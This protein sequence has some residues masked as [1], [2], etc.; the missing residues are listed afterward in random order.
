[1]ESFIERYVLLYKTTESAD[2]IIVQFLVE[3][4][5]GEAL[6]ASDPDVLEIRMGTLREMELQILIKLVEVYKLDKNKVA[7]LLKI[8]RTTLWKKLKTG[9]YASKWTVN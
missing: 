4:I 2:D 1:L 7:D 6:Q 3:K 8:S 9:P 5:S